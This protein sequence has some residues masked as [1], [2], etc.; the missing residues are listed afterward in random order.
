M[1]FPPDPDEVDE[2]LQQTPPKPEFRRSIGE[3]APSES[4][5]RL[6]GAAFAA[7]EA[8]IGIGRAGRDPGPQNDEASREN[9]PID[10]E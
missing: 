10:E 8:G 6:M 7:E 3:E 9:G 1:P 2:P 5:R 4:W